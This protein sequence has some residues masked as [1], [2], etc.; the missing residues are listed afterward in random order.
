MLF[1][2]FAYLLNLGYGSEM[3]FGAR[4]NGVQTFLTP[5]H[6]LFQAMRIMFLPSAVSTILYDFLA[7]YIFVCKPFTSFHMNMHY[8]STF[9]ITKKR[10]STFHIISIYQ[11]HACCTHGEK[12]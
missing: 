10:L 6:V 5:W 4:G 11:K 9:I 1:S 2:D 12:K 8:Y 7:C 3:A